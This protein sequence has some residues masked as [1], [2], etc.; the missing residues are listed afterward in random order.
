MFKIDSK[1]KLKGSLIAE[2][3]GKDCNLTGTIVGYAHKREVP[4]IL[5]EL[6]RGFYNQDETIYVSTLLVD[7]SNL[8]PI[9]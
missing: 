6:D 2:F 1:V 3:A 9:T 4:M 8:S 5:V 7:S